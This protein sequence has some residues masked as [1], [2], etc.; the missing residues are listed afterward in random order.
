MK[1]RMLPVLS[2]AAVA[3]LVGALLGGGFL[4][5]RIGEARPEIAPVRLAA[6]DLE[7]VFESSNERSKLEKQMRAEFD[8]EFAK[9]QGMKNEIDTLKKELDMVKPGSNEYK[10]IQKQMIAK[11]ANLKV[12]QDSVEA[13]ITAK[14][15]TYFARVLGEIK[16]QVRSYAISRGIDVVLQI[17]LTVIKGS[18][19]W[20][21]VFYARPHLDI[22][23]D[24][25]A[26]VN[27]K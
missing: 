15:E 4:T 24:I 1:Q 18:P 3:M 16:N 26:L 19:P 17:Q 8:L 25:I 10:N 13:E 5:P 2:V 21:S 7:R 6:I 20:Q 9:L 12:E 27:G 23:D 14:Q 22:T 11:G